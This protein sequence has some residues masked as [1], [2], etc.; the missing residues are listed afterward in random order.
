MPPHRHDVAIPYRY[1]H[2]SNDTQVYHADCSIVYICI[3]EGVPLWVCGRNLTFPTANL[4]WYH[5]HFSRDSYST[6]IHRVTLPGKNSME[7]IFKAK[8]LKSTRTRGWVTSHHKHL[9][10]QSLVGVTEKLSKVWSRYF[11][12]NLIVHNWHW[13]LRAMWRWPK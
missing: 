2:R 13:C 4:E 11:G 6:F 5:V 12:T 8:F 3:V 9:V 7:L 1:D 10:C